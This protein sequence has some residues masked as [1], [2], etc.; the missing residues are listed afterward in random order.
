MVAL[1]PPELRLDGL[2]AAER[3]IVDL[4]AAGRSNAEIARN[5]GTSVR[6][7]AN[8]VAALLGKVGAVSRHDLVARL[9]RFV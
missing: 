4:L 7:V 3:D 9:G 8:Q 6:T 1:S 5:R 2:T